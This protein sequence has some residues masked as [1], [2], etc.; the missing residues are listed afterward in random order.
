VGQGTGAADQGTVAAMR[1][2]SWNRL[3]ARVF[4]LFEGSG[5]VYSFSNPRYHQANETAV[6]GSRGRR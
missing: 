6:G 3:V 1:P 4:A 2:V 5:E